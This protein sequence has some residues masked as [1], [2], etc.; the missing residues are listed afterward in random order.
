[1]SSHHLNVGS[2]LTGLTFIRRITYA[3]ISIHMRAC[4]H[5]HVLWEGVGRLMEVNL[6]S[7]YAVNNRCK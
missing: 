2:F 5:T 3:G 7:K 1:M 6:E 4:M